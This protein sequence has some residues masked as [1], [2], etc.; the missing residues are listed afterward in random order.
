LSIIVR[1]PAALADRIG[2]V[3]QVALP[4]ASVRT[5]LNELVLAY[6][7]LQ[8][9][10]W[11]SAAEINPVILLFRNNQLMRPL[12]LELILADGDQLDIVPSIEA[13]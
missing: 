6:P 2:G 12:D 3:A 9:V 10:I 1:L 4:A 13:G 7:A 11:H 5:C 8:R